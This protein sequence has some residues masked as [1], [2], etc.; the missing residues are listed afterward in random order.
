M[1][2]VDLVRYKKA[3]FLAT[4]NRTD[5][6][7][8]CLESIINAKGIENY[9][10]FVIQQDNNAKTAAVLESFKSRI[11][12]VMAVKSTFNDPIRNINANRVL[13]YKHAFEKL[14]CEYV[15]AIED[16]TLISPDA[17][18]FVDQM[19]EQ[20]AGD[21]SLGCINLISLGSSDESLCAFSYFRSPLVGQGSAIDLRMW[22]ELKLD[23]LQNRFIDEPFDG[24]IE[25]LM[26]CKKNIFPN[27]SRIL[28][29]GWVGTHSSSKNDPYFTKMQESWVKNKEECK[30]FEHVQRELGLREDW[31][32][33]KR[34]Q[35]LY[36]Y[37]RKRILDLNR[38]S[39]GNI[40]INSLRLIMQKP[41]IKKLS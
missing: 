41:K 38:T 5:L 16:D 28:D 32:E 12:E 14:G 13:G 15:V 29:Q 10:F 8:R 9:F 19:Y 33:Y 24:A 21:D 31:I 4:F 22:Q 20:H 26:K 18:V 35:D 6:L 11:N 36:F 17:L 25:D 23:Q 27:R 7:Q 3:I 37:F 1:E 34:N 2:K 39:I 30:L 40:L